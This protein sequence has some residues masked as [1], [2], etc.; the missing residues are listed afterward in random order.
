MVER[1]CRWFAKAAAVFVMVAAVPAQ[2][3]LTGF[4]TF[5]GNYGLSTDGWGGSD[6]VGVISA[7]VPSGSTIVAAYLY[8]ATQF[9]NQNALPTSVLLDGM[10]VTYDTSFPN[11]TSCCS[12]SSHRAD[13]TSIVQGV[14]GSGGGVFDFDIAEGSGNSAIDGSALV[15]VFENPVLPDATVGLLNGFANV[16]GDTTSINFIDPLDPTDPNFFAEMVLAINFSCCD[17]RSLV[18]VNGSL[19]TE[20]A[21]NFDDGENQANGSLITVGSFDDPFSPAN[22]TYDQDTERYDLST[23]ISSGDT[24]IVVDTFNAS[25]DDNIF[26][27]GFYVSGIAGIN[28]P[29]PTGDVPVP[30]TLLLFGAGLIGLSRVF[31]V[32]KAVG[33]DDR[34]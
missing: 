3:G 27:A 26:L 9:S 5:N 13:V 7:S 17:Q 12:L 23:F 8:T 19:L 10:T 34:L 4:Q 18:Q 31:R 21:G 1:L 11:A 16:S 32:K 20:N 28:E 15:V 2:A 22:P 14:V 25:Q 29:P 30:G 6:G 33:L 24:S